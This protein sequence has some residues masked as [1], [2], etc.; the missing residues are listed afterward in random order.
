MNGNLISDFQIFTLQRPH[1][2]S[3]DEMTKYHSDDYIK[4]LKTIK[5]DNMT[6]YTKQM[7]RCKLQPSSVLDLVK[8]V[9]TLQYFVAGF[10]ASALCF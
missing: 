1:K 7:Q 8:C 4:F 3:Q 2:A 9:H 10:S 5:P 6:E